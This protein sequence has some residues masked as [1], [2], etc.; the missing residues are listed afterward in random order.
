[1]K[2]FSKTIEIKTQKVFDFIKINHQVEKVILESKVKNGFA[3]LRSAH[4]TAALICFESDSEA[5]EDLKNILKKL[6]PDDF[7]WT[8]TMEGTNNARAHQAVALLGQTHW[9]PIENGQ[10]KLGTWQSI[11]LIEFFQGRTRKITVSIIGE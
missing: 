11:F 6:L 9:L 4:T 8:H 10:I 5:I 2:F 3:L 1:M 7:P